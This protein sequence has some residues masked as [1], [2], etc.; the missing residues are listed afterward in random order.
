F[1]KNP[2]KYKSVS[3]F[4]PICNPMNAPCYLRLTPAGQKAFTG[5]FRYESQETW[6]CTELLKIFHRKL[7]VLIDVGLW[8]NSTSRG[9]CCLRILMRPQERLLI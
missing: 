6:K 9:S 2:G 3:A 7:N 1:L 5:Y 8:I 4:A